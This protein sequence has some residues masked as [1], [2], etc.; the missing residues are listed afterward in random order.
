MSVNIAGLN[1][2]ELLAYVWNY[3]GSFAGM[4]GNPAGFAEVFGDKASAEEAL[5]NG[6]NYVDY[7]NGRPIKVDFSKDTV[8]PFLFDRD[9][10][11]GTFARAV[12]NFRLLKQSKQGRTSL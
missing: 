5:K 11:Q 3:A 4:R 8:N 9:A 12:E 10:G 1:K 2:A 7:F 6:R